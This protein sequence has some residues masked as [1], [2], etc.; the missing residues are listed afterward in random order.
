MLSDVNAI[1][2]V[3]TVALTALVILAADWFLPPDDPR[4]PVWLALASLVATGLVILQAWG[5]AMTPTPAFSQAPVGSGGAVT[6]VAWVWHDSFG[7]FAAGILVLTAMVTVLLSADYAR[8]RPALAR[9]EYY[10]LVLI[11]IAAMMLV[12][13][14]NDLILIFLGIE[15]FSI[16]LYIL[17]GFVRGDRLSHE[18]A[19]KYFVLGAFAAGFLL[20]GIALVYASTGTT[21]LSLIGRALAAGAGSL[22]GVTYVGLGL[23]LV[24]L[25]FK[26]AMAPFHQW[27]PDVYEGAPLTVTALMAAGTKTAAFAALARVLWSGFA[28]LADAWLPLL[29]ALAVVTM[30]VGNLAALV[31]VDLKR[32]L[33]FS[34]VAHAGYLLVA[35]VAGS[36][37]GTSAMLFY[38]LVYALMNLGAFGVLVALGPV[39]PS[40]RDATNLADLRGMAA[41]HPGLALALAVFLFSLTGL[42]PTAGFLGKWYIFQAAVASDHAWLAVAVVLNSVLSAFYYLRPVLLMALADPADLQPITVPRA[43]AAAVTLAAV[44]VGLLIILSVPL[45]AGLRAAVMAGALP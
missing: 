13:M 29:G 18:A 9:A 5:P 26:V 23:I 45:G 32:M 37:A 22:P 25:G 34:A 1:L 41:R 6:A 15:T 39:G 7:L 24:G 38:L 43:S 4:P 28:P 2:P 27:T 12:G 33:A 19:L 40:G 31:Q 11:A 16:A 10:V 35:V 3:L 30:V 21:N 44:A 8:R 17:C 36:P 14:A 20:Y 42:P